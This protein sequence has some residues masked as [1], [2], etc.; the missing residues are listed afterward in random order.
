MSNVQEYHEIKNSQGAILGLTLKKAFHKVLRGVFSE[1]KEHN[2][3]L[4]EHQ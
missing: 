2:Y 3:D 1:L 4:D